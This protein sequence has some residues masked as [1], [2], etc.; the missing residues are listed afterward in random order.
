VL[1]K[2]LILLANTEVRTGERP[3]LSPLLF[4]LMVRKMSVKRKCGKLNITLPAPW[5]TILFEKLI[6]IQLV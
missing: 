3:A 5:C 6:V 1:L 2:I 4:L